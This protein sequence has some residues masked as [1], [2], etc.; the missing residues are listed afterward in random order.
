MT[1]NP[2]PERLAV[3]WP[4]PPHGRP[5]PPTAAKLEQDQRE[6]LEKLGEALF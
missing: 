3:G 2:E 5:V 6:E 1:E 4:F